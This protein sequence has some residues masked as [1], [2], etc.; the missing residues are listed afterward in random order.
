MPMEHF[1]EPALMEGQAPGDTNP[2]LS[3]EGTHSEPGA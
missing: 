3:C 2:I 1:R